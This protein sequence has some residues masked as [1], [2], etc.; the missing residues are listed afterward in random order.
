MVRAKRFTMVNAYLRPFPNY[1]GVP[2]VSIAILVRPE[3]RV[4]LGADCDF[5]GD[6]SIS[7]ADSGGFH[8]ADCA[9]LSNNVRPK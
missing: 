7:G 4:T 2:L 8:D 9:V 5:V 6:H 1:Y 3:L